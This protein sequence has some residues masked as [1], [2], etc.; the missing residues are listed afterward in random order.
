MQLY[1]SYRD[2]SRLTWLEGVFHDGSTGEPAEVHHLV[3]RARHTSSEQ[4]VDLA[5]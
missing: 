1:P 4:D 5:M 2:R 3:E